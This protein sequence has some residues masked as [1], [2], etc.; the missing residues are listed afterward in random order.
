MTLE[1]S[2]LIPTKTNPTPFVVAFLAGNVV[3]SIVFPSF[4]FTLWTRFDVSVLPC[5]CIKLII[6]NICTPD[7]AMINATTFHTDFLPAFT[8]CFRAKS[9]SF[10]DILQTAISGTPAKIRIKVDINLQSEPDVL[11]KES[12]W[13]KCLDISFQ[14]FILTAMLHTWDL[15][16][17]T[18]LN[19]STQMS[20]QTSLAELV[21]AGETKKFRKFLLFIADVAK[22]VVFS[23]RFWLFHLRNNISHRHTFWNYK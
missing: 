13:A 15:N 3:A 11:L 20:F 19:V 2:L 5:P 9:A 7:P 16:H 10:S 22:N 8:S 4:D 1:T 6:A 17:L 12:L 14:E 18:I 23:K 21:V